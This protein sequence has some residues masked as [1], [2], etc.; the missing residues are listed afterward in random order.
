MQPQEMQPKEQPYMGLAEI[1]TYL[2]VSKPTVL[3][4][5]VQCREFPAPVA[6]L[7][8]GPVWATDA[9]VKFKAAKKGAATKGE[10]KEGGR[11]AVCRWPR[12]RSASFACVAC[13]S[14]RR[15]LKPAGVDF[16]G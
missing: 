7:R 3:N 8:M 9:V 11:V 15:W 4:W 6:D 1:A 16:S 2:T 12:S 5:R 13:L 10:G 14:A